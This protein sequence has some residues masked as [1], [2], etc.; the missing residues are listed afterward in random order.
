[1]RSSSGHGGGLSALVETALELGSI[2][3][4]DTIEVYVFDASQGRDVFHEDESLLAVKRAQI[5]AVKDAT[6]AIGSAAVEGG[7]AA[8][9][10]GASVAG[11]TG[12]GPDSD[13]VARMGE[14]IR[15]QASAGV[16][17]ALNYLQPHVD[18]YAHDPIFLEMA[19]I[20]QKAAEELGA[21]E[22]AGAATS[23]DI[24]GHI[25]TEFTGLQ[26]PFAFDCRDA[27]GG[28]CLVTRAD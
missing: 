5:G 25:L 14:A 13:V 24:R 4:D 7:S 12:E 28:D 20:L 17:A 15:H 2:A 18:S 8:V 11:A 21:S 10:G 22:H 26:V 9:E 27:D 19:A 16:L 1:M 23:D 3:A 6:P